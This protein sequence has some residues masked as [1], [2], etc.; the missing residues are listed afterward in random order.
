[1]MARA[2]WAAGAAWDRLSWVRA[3]RSASVSVRSGSFLRRDIGGL[4]VTR[5]QRSY[6]ETSIM[7]IGEANDPLVDVGLCS[8]KLADGQTLQSDRAGHPD[9]G[10]PESDGR[11]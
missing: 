6:P 4:R 7:A 1:M 5:G 9:R 10:R 2:T 11:V 8:T 3:R